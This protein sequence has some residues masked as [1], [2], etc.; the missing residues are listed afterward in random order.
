MKNLQLFAYSTGMSLFSTVNLCKVQI[1]N[2]YN[3]MLQTGEASVF[4][5]QKIKEV[6]TLDNDLSDFEALDILIEAAES[7]L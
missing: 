6:Q 3:D 5:S 2:D 1:L 7:A 4:L